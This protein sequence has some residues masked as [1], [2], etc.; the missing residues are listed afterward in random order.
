M[1]QRITK[2]LP[3]RL[4]TIFG[5]Q[6]VTS[7]IL[8]TTMSLGVW[9]WRVWQMQNGEN[10][11]WN[12]TLHRVFAACNCTSK[13]EFYY[14][15]AATF[16]RTSATIDGV[17]QMLCGLTN[18][19]LKVPQQYEESVRSMSSA[20]NNMSQVHT[21]SISTFVLML[22]AA[23]CSFAA[24]ICL[25]KWCYISFA[26]K[27]KRWY[28]AS[29]ISLIA[30]TIS[31]GTGILL[32]SGAVNLKSIFNFLPLTT[33]QPVAGG[34]GWGL[35][36]SVLA[37]FN[38]I[39]L[40]FLF[41][42]WVPR[43]VH[44]AGADDYAHYKSKQ[45][46]M[47]QGSDKKQKQKRKNANRRQSN[48]DLEAHQHL[49]QQQHTKGQ[50]QPPPSD[51]T[52]KKLFWAYVPEAMQPQGG[53]QY[54][55]DVQRMEAET[56]N[57]YNMTQAPAMTQQYGGANLYEATTTY[58]STPMTTQQHYVVQGPTAVQQVPAAYMPV[59]ATTVNSAYVLQQPVYDTAGISAAA[60]AAYMVQQPTTVDAAAYMVQQPTTVD[61]AAYMVQQ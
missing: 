10:L 50:P 61:A 55:Q 23:L 11:L 3:R 54:L 38:Y 5:L 51:G 14:F 34:F 7:A 15:C 56:I 25:F 60:P 39:L 27:R 33:L 20:C 44:L 35:W 30:S 6:V 40:L 57:N 4:W 8:W 9:S 36:L 2:S 47:H 41:W 43:G 53:G 17:K 22:V 13:A 16:K 42:K 12:V 19:P 18:A 46:A 58:M 21:A 1:V 52:N 48:G 59:D 32:Y 45:A 24:V 28:W 37:F 29:A 49:L 31:T 26:K